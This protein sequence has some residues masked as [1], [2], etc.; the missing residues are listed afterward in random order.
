MNSQIQWM[1]P[2]EKIQLMR[3][4]LVGT[5]K[6]T[7]FSS[8]QSAAPWFEERNRTLFL[9]PR[10]PC[11]AIRHSKSSQDWPNSVKVLFFDY[12]HCSCCKSCC[13]KY[14]NNKRC[15]KTIN[16]RGRRIVED[17]FMIANSQVET[18]Q[19][20]F[21]GDKLYEVRFCDLHICYTSPV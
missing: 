9:E 7:N 19:F 10:M 1:V 5:K 6:E 4:L 8:K 17:I 3:F 21:K 15:F 16:C 14:Q 20:W 12:V 13:R 11:I 2:E 18:W